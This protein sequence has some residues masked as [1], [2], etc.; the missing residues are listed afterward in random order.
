MGEDHGDASPAGYRGR[1]SVQH[2]VSWKD[3]WQQCIRHALTTQQWH[4]RCFVG[5]QVPEVGRPESVAS[6]RAGQ[7]RG[8]IGVRNFLRWCQV[9]LEEALQPACQC[10]CSPTL[11]G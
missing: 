10:K 3:L 6:A 4:G 5:V 11:S 7:R 2:V 1:H 9:R 8:S